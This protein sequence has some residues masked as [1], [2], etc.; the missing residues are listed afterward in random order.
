MDT[1]LRRMTAVLARL[2]KVR[3]NSTRGAFVIRTE[4]GATL[5][6][7][8]NSDGDIKAG[9]HVDEIAVPEARRGRGVG[10]KAM[11]ALCRLADEGVW[12]MKGGPIGWSDD[13]NGEKSVRW[14]GRFG[15]ERD[16]S[17]PTQLHDRAAFYVRRLPRPPHP[18]RL[19]GSPG[20][21]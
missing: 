1:N 18:A 4:L 21:L 19:G 11:A 10:T 16:P 12:I 13:P 3:W 14:L 15:V 5:Q 8:P 9:F 17:P 7:C 2:G 20:S 6:L